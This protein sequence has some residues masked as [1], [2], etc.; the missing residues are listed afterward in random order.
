MAVI[1]DNGSGE[2]GKVAETIDKMYYFHNEEVILEKSNELEK[3]Y[4]IRNSDAEELL[5]EV[6]EYLEIFKERF[7]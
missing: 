6:N 5:K 4:S 3:E 1:E 7:P 2:R